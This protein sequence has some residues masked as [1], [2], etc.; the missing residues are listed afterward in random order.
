MLIITSKRNQ[1]LQLVLGFG[2]RIVIQILV[3]TIFGKTLTIDVESS[4]TIEKVKKK[5]QDK[6]G[7][8][9]EEQRLIF[10]GKQLEDNKNVSYYNIQNQSILHLVLRYRESNRAMQIFVKLLNGKNITLDVKSSD[11]IEIIKKK[12]QD[13]EGIP[14]NQQKLMYAARELED[15]RTLNDYNIQKQ[16][17]LHLILTLNQNGK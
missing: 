12:I 9:P 8:T 14:P 16:T 6:E 15:N 17:T 7:Y 10:P 3:K 13:K 5:I 2:A 1:F 4:D 11:T